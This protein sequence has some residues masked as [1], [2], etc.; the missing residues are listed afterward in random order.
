LL[1]VNGEQIGVR[2]R[3][4]DLSAYYGTKTKSIQRKYDFGLVLKITS[5]TYNPL[6]RQ[7]YQRFL[8]EMIGFVKQYG[9][10][11]ERGRLFG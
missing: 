9:G 1:P 4:V 7:V 5:Q 10:D 8:T 3:Y 2:I 11:F 6:T